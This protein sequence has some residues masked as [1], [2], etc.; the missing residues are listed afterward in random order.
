MFE[1]RIVGDP[2]EEAECLL[3]QSHRLVGGTAPRKELE[4]VVDWLN[5]HF[6][7]LF[8]QVDG[9]YHRIEEVQDGRP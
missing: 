1:F 3:T 4:P 9:T 5:Q 7:T 6:H 2:G 8:V